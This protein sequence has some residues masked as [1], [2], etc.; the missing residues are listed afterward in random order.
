MRIDAHAHLW[1]LAVRDQPWTA[2]LPALRR[3]FSI[4][5]LAPSLDTHGIDSVVLVQTVCVA[6]ET[7]EMLALAAREP[8][9]AGVVGWVDL[10]A[11]DVTAHL[12]ALRAAE[13]GAA[14][15]GIRHQV[16]EEDDPRWL[17]RP[18]VRRGLSEVA[19]AGLAYELVVR[20]PQLAAVLD[21]ARAIPRL[22]FVLDHG[23][24]PDVSGSPSPRWR[25]A[26]SELGALPNMAAKLSGLTSEGGA[27]WTVEG[28]R[29][30]AEALIG[31]FAAD[32]LMFGSDW[33]V[34]LL[35]GGYDATIDATGAWLGGC[36]PEQRELVFGA[37]AARVYG[38]GPGGR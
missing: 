31:A 25:E 32:R 11:A 12:R 24:K 23:A 5:D 9:V 37:T 18:D 28:L 34:C 2:S 36:S 7:P 1:D 27:N 19:D 14:L 17:C 20:P 21:T 22:R 10:T 6:E 15:I 33:P 38:F 16:Q 29:P 8:R 13:G 4:D 30:F 3:S 35:G 26:I